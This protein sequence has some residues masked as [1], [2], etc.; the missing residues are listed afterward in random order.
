MSKFLKTAFIIVALFGS[1]F[2]GVT[3]GEATLLARQKPTLPSTISSQLDLTEFWQVWRLTGAKYVDPTAVDPQKMLYGAMAGVVKSLGDPFSEFLPPSKTTEFME[4]LESSLTGIGAEIGLRDDL[5]TV[6]SPLRGSPAEAAGL[7]PGDQILKIDDVLATDYSVSEAVQH[8]RG[9]VGTTVKLLVVRADTPGPLEL[10]IV[11]ARV[12]IESVK[13]ELKDGVGVVTVASFAEDTASEFE[14]KLHELAAQ[15]P[16][17]LVL[18]LRF[19]GGGFLDAAVKMAGQFLPAGTPVVTI[20]ERGL[21]DEITRTSGTPTFP[22]LPVVVLVNGGSASAAEILAGALQD[23]GRAKVLGEESFGKGSVQELVGNFPDG[24]LL[25]ITVAKWL[26]P[27]GHDVT[28]AKIQPDTVVKMTAE[29][30]EKK[31]DPQLEAALAAA[32]N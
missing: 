32:K 15:K 5:L 26:T 12:Q 6:I 25:K 10:K 21:P 8:I 2:L 23:A 20:R 18:D 29:D 7:R 27:A 22:N 13:T 17:G 19:N 9:P 4:G 30:Y 3:H 1:Y 11:R 24:A 28:T 14:R 16:R 31:R